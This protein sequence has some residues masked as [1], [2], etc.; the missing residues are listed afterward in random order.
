MWLLTLAELLLALMVAELVLRAVLGRRS[1]RAAA[2]AEG[3]A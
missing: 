3:A 1:E 2:E